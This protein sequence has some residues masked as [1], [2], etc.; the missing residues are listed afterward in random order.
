MHAAGPSSSLIA[1]DFAGASLYLSF[2][3]LTD[4]LGGQPHRPSFYEAVEP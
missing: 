2:M 4:P 3:Q 1:E